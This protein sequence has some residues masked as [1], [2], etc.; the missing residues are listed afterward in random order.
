[1]RTKSIRYADPIVSSNTKRGE[2]KGY[3]GVVAI[4]RKGKWEGGNTKRLVLKS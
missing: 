4:M 1:M 2:I 3:V